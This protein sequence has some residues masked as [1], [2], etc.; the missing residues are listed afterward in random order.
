MRRNATRGRFERKRPRF[1]S[2]NAFARGR[3]QTAIGISD[4]RAIGGPK[5]GRQRAGPVR[6]HA[7]ARGRAQRAVAVRRFSHPKGSERG[8]AY[9]R[10]HE[11]AQ[12]HQSQN[13]DQR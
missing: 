1:R 6:L 10:R 2:T 13:A 8:R 5:C 9:Q 3:L 11:R 7:A 4:R 12:H